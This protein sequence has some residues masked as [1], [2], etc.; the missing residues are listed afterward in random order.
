MLP[1]GWGHLEGV[2]VLVGSM[3]RVYEEPLGWDM[4]SSW[5]KRG[6]VIQ[7]REFLKLAHFLGKNRQKTDTFSAK[8]RR[9]TGEDIIFQEKKHALSSF[10]F[11]SCVVI[12]AF[13]CDKLLTGVN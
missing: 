11:S 13:Y 6:F 7:C 4:A 10:A 9:K 8:T 3:S 2:G 1:W 12:Y 5:K